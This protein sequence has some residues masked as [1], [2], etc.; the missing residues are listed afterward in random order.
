MHFIVEYFTEVVLF[1]IGAYSDEIYSAVI[2][3]PW[4]PGRWNTVFVA[5]FFGFFHDCVFFAN[6]I[7]NWALCSVCF[8]SVETA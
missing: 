7:I 2:A 4:C 6:I 5:E 8:S 1:V 3:V